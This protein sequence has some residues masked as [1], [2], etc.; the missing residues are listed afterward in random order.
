L[1]LDVLFLVLE[2]ADEDSIMEI[3]NLNENSKYP[4]SCCG[5]EPETVERRESK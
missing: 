3:N 5:K 1:I 2:T 4:S